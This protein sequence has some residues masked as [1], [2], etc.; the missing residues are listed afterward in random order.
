MVKWTKQA[1]ADYRARHPHRACERLAGHK[2]F[3]E[4]EPI[5][6]NHTVYDGFVERGWIVDTEVAK[7]CRSEA[8]KQTAKFQGGT[9]SSEQRA[10]RWRLMIELCKKYRINSLTRLTIEMGFADCATLT[11][12]CNKYGRELAKKY[13]KLPKINNRLNADIWLEIMEQ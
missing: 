13:G 6:R 1:E 3:Y 5:T 10:D 4:G 9:T 11:K 12:F 2:A 7:V 8:N